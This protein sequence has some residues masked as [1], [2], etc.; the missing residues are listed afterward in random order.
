MVLDRDVPL[1][2]IVD[3]R[4]EIDWRARFPST[5]H[6]STQQLCALS[7]GQ[8]PRSILDCIGAEVSIELGHKL[9]N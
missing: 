2:G 4:R 8:A 9:G 5:E 6:A 7:L 3:S 1:T